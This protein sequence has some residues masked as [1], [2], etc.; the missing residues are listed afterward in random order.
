VVKRETLLAIIWLAASVASGATFTVTKTSDDPA[1]GCDA[2]CSLREAVIAANAT[3]EHDTIVVP[4]G[5]YLLSLVGADEDAAAT[6]DLDLNEDVTI[7]GDPAGGTIIDGN[8]SDRVVHVNGATVELDDLVLTRGRTLGDWFGAGGI[9]VESGTLTMIRCVLSDCFS[10]GHGGGIFSL[11]T[12]T[13]DRSAVTGNIGFNGGAIYHAGDDL[14]LV[15]TTVSGNAATDFGSGGVSTDGL[16]L[17]ASIDSCTITNN[18]GAES[19]AVSVLSEVHVANTIFDGSCEVAPGMGTVVSGGGNLES[20]ADT[21]GLDHPTDLVGVTP[22]ELDLGPLQNNGGVTPTHAPR[23]GS[24]AIDSGNHGLCPAVDQRDWLRWDPGCDIGSL[25]VSA[26][27]GLIFADGF[28]SG[29][30]GTWSGFASDGR[31]S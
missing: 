11:G 6:G 13:L 14:V 5:T 29:D 23:S 28:E 18:V 15:N 20:P 24:I 8:L 19:G 26:V 22:A 7:I 2:D 27:E 17:A 1:D 31:Q 10:D 9:L 12:V 3:V 30:T 21:C 16:A 25:E 4:A